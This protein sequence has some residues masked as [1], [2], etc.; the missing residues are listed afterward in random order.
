MPVTTSPP[1]RGRTKSEEKR[2]QIICSAAKLFLEQGFESASM[3]KIARNAGVS[4]QTVYSHFGT[5]EQL[6]SS[7]I[8]AVIDD[9]ELGQSMAQIADPET[10]LRSFC[11]HFA[12]LLISEEALGIHKVC[13]GDAGRSNVGALFWEA[14]PSKIRQQLERFLHRQVDSGFLVIAD[15]NTACTQL[16][17]LLHGEQQ[18]C[19]VMGLPSEHSIEESREKTKH[20]AQACAD[21]FLKAYRS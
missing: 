3:D 16:M 14:G 15:I 20:Y 10:Y 21:L 18:N 6:F 13:V 5:K 17:A 12:L 11:E 4:K 1:R 9:Y 19:A 7:A 8:E 2:S